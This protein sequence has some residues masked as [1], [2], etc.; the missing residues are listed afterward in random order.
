M[1]KYAVITSV[2]VVMFCCSDTLIYGLPL[3][4]WYMCRSSISSACGGDKT[5]MCNRKAAN[6]STTKIT[7]IKLRPGH[8]GLLEPDQT[9][10][11]HHKKH[12]Q[13]IY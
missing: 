8:M 6:H 1:N 5:H 4:A 9:V 2:L 12:I 7:N 11:T 3:G 10:D 13:N